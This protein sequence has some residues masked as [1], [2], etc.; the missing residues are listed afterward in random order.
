M[1][2]DD[3]TTSCASYKS[4]IKIMLHNQHRDTL[5]KCSKINKCLCI[6]IE[7]AT[8]VKDESYQLSCLRLH[9]VN[10]KTIFNET[11]TKLPIHARNV[12]I[13]K[14]NQLI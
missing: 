1:G 12:C 14:Q 6:L 8:G 3:F 7:Y 13:L 10:D 11:I 2:H 5:V 4:V 9:K